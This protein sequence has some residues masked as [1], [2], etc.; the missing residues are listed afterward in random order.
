MTRKRYTPT[1]KAQVELT[2]FRGPLSRWGTHPQEESLAKTSRHGPPSPPACR[3]EA[4][5]RAR[6]SG[7]S[8]RQIADD[9]GRTSDTRRWW[10]KQAA[11][12]AGK[13]HDGLTSAE[14]AEL[15]RLRRENRLLGEERAIFR[16]A[17]AHLP[18]RISR[19]GDRRAPVRV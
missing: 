19:A 15:R 4:R 8:Q 3:A 6:T 11:R 13:R 1:F 14:Q 2:D 16:T 9:L 5:R 17:A 7:Q 10:R 18:R 12:D